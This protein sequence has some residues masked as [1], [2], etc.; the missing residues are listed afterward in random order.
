MC[1]S[2]AR[3][4]KTDASPFFFPDQLKAL[5]SAAK[6][7]QVD[8]IYAISPGLDI[9]FSNPKEV[10]ALKRKLDQVWLFCL[11][12]GGPCLTVSWALFN[13]GLP[14]VKRAAGCCL[15]REPA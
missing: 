4:K 2:P 7:H 13:V 10:A 1:W 9:T 12:F 6:Q 3:I 15:G 11:G 5:I 14:A 8:F